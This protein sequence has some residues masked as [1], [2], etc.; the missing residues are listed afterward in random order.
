MLLVL[1]AALS[2]C[3]QGVPCA[4][5]TPT[6]DSLPPFVLA[7][8]AA[9]PGLSLARA[10][11]VNIKANF[12]LGGEIE[13]K[14]ASGVVVG[15]APGGE[16][17]VVTAYH[18]FGN[19]ETGE[20]YNLQDLEVQ[21]VRTSIVYL[22]WDIERDI[23]VVLLLDLKDLPVIAFPST[24]PALCQT[25]FTVGYPRIPNLDHEHLTVI[26]NQVVEVNEEEIVVQ[27]GTF[28]GG[29]GSGVVNDKGELIGLC[30]ESNV[31]VEKLWSTPAKHVYQLLQ[32]ALE[33]ISSK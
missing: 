16:P 4:Q 3:A 23:I 13:A 24:P 20:L 6:E 31:I 10:A 21:G 25:V 17:L 18:L 26:V 14:G 2:A 9:E 32:E 19:N 29:S 5:E 28:P 22:S 8:Q 11:S 30:V 33:M 27:P 7:V 15:Q 12:E 1:L